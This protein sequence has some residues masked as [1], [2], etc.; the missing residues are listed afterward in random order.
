[1][2]GKDVC[3]GDHKVMYVSYYD[4][5]LGTLCCVY[6]YQASYTQCTASCMQH[7]SLMASHIVMCNNDPL[8]KTIVFHFLVLLVSLI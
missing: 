5:V 1:M 8:M 3:V 7:D 6:L 2:M 4:I